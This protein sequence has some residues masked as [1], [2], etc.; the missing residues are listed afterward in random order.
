M[1]NN[2][3]AA[4]DL[5][6]LG[7]RNLARIYRNLP[8]PA[9]YEE[10]IRRREGSI[11]YR[12]PFVVRTGQYTGRSPDDKFIVKEPL[13]QG[14]IWWGTSNMPMEEKYF[15]RLMLRLQAYWQGKDMFIQDCH[16]GADERYRI[17]LRVVTED[18]WHSMFARDM[19]IRIKDQDTLDHHNPEY[20]VFNAPRFTADPSVDGT[21]SEAFVVVHFGK[22]IVIIGGTSYAGEIKKSVFNLLNYEMPQKSVLSMHCSANVGSGGDVAVFFG[23]SGTGKTTLSADPSRKLIGDDEHGWSDGGVFNFEGGCYAKVINLSKEAEPVIFAN[24]QR[25]GTILE[26]VAMEFSMFRKVDLNDGALTENT[27]AAFPITEVNVPNAELSGVCGH[28]KN[29]FMLTADA[30]GVLPPI[31]RLTPD[32]A[33]YHFISGYTA[34]VAGTERGI[35]E[36]VATFSTCFGRPF[37]ALH[38]SVYAKLLGEKIKQHDVKCWLLNTGWT[39]GPYG[40]GNRI[41]IQHSRAL[42]NAAIE[43][44][45]DEVESVEDPNFGF[46]APAKAPGVPEG[47][48]SPR[49]TWA[50][51]DA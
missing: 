9:L 35:K 20:H 42:L 45:L 51:K 30:F 46:M 21:N 36:P 15:D 44:K 48:M 8:I 3:K 25:F 49:D 23:L 29:I 18:A 24:T 27:R 39:G 50:D 26:N 16:A 47:I 41:S 40:V 33:S 2:K 31:A 7:F 4:D 19:F 1:P 32:E 13:S 22:R 43:G 17:P 14:R 38:P 10:A 28:P 5:E 37:L 6:K 34:K 12:G 11:S